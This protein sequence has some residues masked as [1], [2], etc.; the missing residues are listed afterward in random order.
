MRKNTFYAVV[1]LVACSFTA[2]AQTQP[3]VIDDME[4]GAGYANEVYYKLDDG[5]K[6]VLPAS[7][8]HLGFSTPVASAGIVINAGLPSA[9]MGAQGMNL[10]VWPNGTNES[11]ETVTIADT[12]GWSSWEKLYN[13]SI[14]YDGAFN[15]NRNNNP[16]DFGWG[17]YDMN[18]H[19]VNGDSVYILK[20]NTK[21]S[22]GNNVENVYKINIVKKDFGT[23]HIQ[24]AD[25]VNASATKSVEIPAS[26]PA[27]AGK[28]FVYFNLLDEQIKDRELLGWDLWAVKYHDNYNNAPTPQEVTGILTHPKYEV[29]KIVVGKDNRAGDNSHKTFADADWSSNKNVIGHTYKGL[30]GFSFVVNDSVVY[31]LK[32]TDNGEVWK[33]YPEAFVGTSAGKT[34]FMKQNMPQDTTENGGGGTTPPP[35][36]GVNDLVSSFVDVYPNPANDQITIVFDSK[37]TTA[38]VSVKNQLGQVVESQIVTTNNGIYQQQIDLT[39]LNSGIYFLEITQNG[40]SIVK[41]ILKK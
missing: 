33:W 29:A 15:Q 26:D 25:L 1:G 7:D 14:S 27:Y 8:W 21:D 4:M 17:V 5:T 10:A 16:F 13:D 30:S 35:T 28:E 38:Q 9:G 36:N 34:T 32:N 24:F 23:Y 3:P 37:A 19:I 40:Y 2:M 20:F 31:Y 39:Q 41:N 6:S 22:D 12:A 18:T 11:F